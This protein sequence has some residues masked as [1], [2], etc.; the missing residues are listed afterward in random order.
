LFIALALINDPEVVFL[1][2]LTTGLD[3]QARRAIWDLVNG[4]RSR[5]KTVFLTTHLMEEA[6]R[7]C[8]RVA[9]IEHGRLIE[10]G[11]P[12]DLVRRH[13][14]ERGVVFSS[15]REGLAGELERIAGTASVRVEGATYTVQGRG[16][17]FVTA[18][19]RF[20]AA[21][22]LTVRDFRTVFP[23]LEDVFLKL[24]GHAIRD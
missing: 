14:P 3:P 23:T 6:E 1:D 15:G 11:A 21:Q 17:D 9:I 20:V 5:G 2:E 22:A 18:V 10:M 19:I 12:A 24:T 16:D 4:I 7:L 13:C 8:D